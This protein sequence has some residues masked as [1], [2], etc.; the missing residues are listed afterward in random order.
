MS[1]VAPGWR[2]FSVV[3]QRDHVVV[4]TAWSAWARWLTTTWS[5][6]CFT[7]IQG[8]QPGYPNHLVNMGT[9]I[10]RL[11]MPTSSTDLDH[12]DD[13][14]RPYGDPLLT[15]PRGAHDHREPASEGHRKPFLKRDGAACSV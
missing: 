6:R 14:A 3:S 13:S 10:N 11:T 9:V 7:G 8:G 1:R 12:L 4:Q 15:Q 2:G 5:S